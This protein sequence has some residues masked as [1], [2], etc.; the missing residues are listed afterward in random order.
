MAKLFDGILSREEAEEI[1]GTEPVAEA[2]PGDVIEDIEAA[3]VA[4]EVS[5]LSDDIE[6]TEEQ[7]E[8]A[9]D[10]VEDLQKAD[11]KLA[12]S[13]GEAPAPVEGETAEGEGEVVEE[14]KEVL[15]P[16]VAVAVANETLRI[17]AKRL[18]IELPGFG[19]SHESATKSPAT[20]VRVSREGIKEVLEKVKSAIKAA[21]EKIKEFFKK[22]WSKI[23]S[24]FGNMESKREQ[25]HKR[26]LALRDKK[27]SILSSDLARDIADKIYIGNKDTTI[28]KYADY[29]Y[30][31][32][33]N[34]K[35]VSELVDKLLSK[36]DSIVDDAN[37]YTIFENLTSE[38][39]GVNKNG[40]HYEEV[41]RSKGVNTGDIASAKYLPLRPSKGEFYV[42][43]DAKATFSSDKFVVKF[44]KYTMEPSKDN[45]EKLADYLVGVTNV[46]NLINALTVLKKPIELSKATNSTFVKLSKTVDKLQLDIDKVENPGIVRN[47]LSYANYTYNSLA[48]LFTSGVTGGIKDA[49]TAISMVISEAE[50][51]EKA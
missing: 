8:E 21:W 5:A 45:K 2:T 47:V 30:N 12:A 9:E 37:A 11:D 35:K 6:A 31:Q 51:T 48:T 24:L 46:Q 36:G 4:E 40:Y 50:K 22:I 16:E 10:V 3:N 39:L 38:K 49:L 32:A 43:H 17:S 14:N 33:D 13:V 28:E 1:L 42:F 34:A 19:I 23:L 20:A 18:G 25:L 29:I 7:I 27:I 41:L 15:P 44:K 26:V